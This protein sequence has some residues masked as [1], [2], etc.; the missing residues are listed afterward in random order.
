MLSSRE[1]RFCLRRLYDPLRAPLRSPLRHVRATFK[2]DDGQALVE[3]ALVLPLLLLLVF[4]LAQL[5]LALN[6][7]NDETHLANEVARFATVNENPGGNNQSLAAWGKTQIDAPGVPKEGTQTVCI[8]LPENKATKTKG[9]LGDPVEVVVKGEREWLPILKLKTIT[10]E[11][12]AV[13]RLE[14]PPTT[15]GEECK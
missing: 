15:Y 11:G 7:A 5:A 10:I 12:K 3:L 1:T 14:A 8:T 9:Q 6:S 2:R 13:M 4:G